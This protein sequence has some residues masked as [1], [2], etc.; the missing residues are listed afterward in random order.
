MKALSIK[1][2]WSWLIVNGYKDIEN[3]DWKTKFRGE[4]LIHA[5]KKFD[6]D[7]WLWAKEN[8]PD[9]PLPHDIE[10]FDLGGIVGKSS[11][12]DCVDQSASPWFFGEYGFVLSNSSPLPFVPYKGQLGFFNVQEK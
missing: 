8:F 10:E 1:Q 5:G 6:K 9:I 11:I 4:F 12:I 7:G 2:P 3:R